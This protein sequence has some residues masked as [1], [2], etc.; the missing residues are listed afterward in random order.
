MTIQTSYTHEDIKGSFLYRFTEKAMPILVWLTITMPIWLSPFHPAVAAYFIL[1]FFI[2]FLYKTVKTAYFGVISLRLLQSAGKIQWSELLHDIPEHAKLEHYVMVVTASASTEK[3]THTLEHIQSQVYDHS[4]IHVVL[5]MEARGGEEAKERSH[6]IHAKYK[7]I[8][9]GLLTTFH[10]L[11]SGEVIG[12]ASNATFACKEISKHIRR[13][14]L[15]PENVLITICDEDSLLPTQYLAYL[16]YKFLKEAEQKYCFFA[17]PV[18]LYNHFWKLPFPVRMQMTLSCVA[19]LAFLSMRDDFIQISTYSTNLWLLESIH[20]WDVDII[21]EDWHIYMQAFYTLGEK[22][23]TVPIYMPIVRDGVLG[24]SLR[25][26]LKARYEQEKR[27]AWGATDV[28]YAVAR[29]FNSPHIN[30]W[31]KLRRLLYLMEVH[32]MW[33]TAFFILTLSASIPSMVNESFERTVMGFLLPK[34]AA[35]ILTIATFFLIF[36]IYFDYS[37]RKRVNIETGWKNIPM[38]FIQWFFMPVVSFFFSSLPA[39]ESHTRML[40]GKKLEYR[41]TEKVG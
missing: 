23:K 17:A 28:P 34:L 20:Y 26:T 25:K 9:G 32:F 30:F 33:P 5:A 8:F 37:L 36:A 27:W 16:T 4:K 29:F 38:L 10:T 7:G 24:P 41:V 22:V 12:K 1:A 2:Y 15:K 35:T 11:T 14:H 19:R 6:Q 39:L 3:L 40:L 31:T 21:P 13:R 18:L